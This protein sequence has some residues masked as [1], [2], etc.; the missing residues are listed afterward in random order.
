[1]EHSEDL[2]AARAEPAASIL[3]G[4]GAKGGLC[5]AGHRNQGGGGRTCFEKLKTKMLNLKFMCC[6]LQVALPS[7][8]LCWGREC[9][10]GLSVSWYKRCIYVFI[11]VFIPWLG[12]CTAWLSPVCG[13]TGLSDV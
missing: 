12:L 13:C 3:P 6:L 5:P 1:M 4:T 10:H 11:D 9:G 7:F 8:L 2:S